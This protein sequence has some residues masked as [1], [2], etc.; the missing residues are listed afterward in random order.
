M[1]GTPRIVVIGGVAAGMS[2]AS[3]AR[4][5]R[6]QAEVIVL[7]RGP[8][9]SYGACGMP[10]N[11]GD[12]RRPI[13]DLV[14]L[15]AERF[16]AE[17]GIDV[18]TGQEALALDTVA[19]T[20]RVLDVAAGRQY[21]L[22]YDALV[23]ATGASAVAPSIPGLGLPGVFRLR[24][25]TDGAA[26]K[27]HL[28]AARPTRAV[29]VGA[30]YIGMEMAEVLTRR[31]LSVT[32]LE[33]LDQVVPGF[34]PAIARLVAQELA[35]HGVR[36]ETGITV[37]AIERLPEAAGA[38]SGDPLVVRT[39]RGAFLAGLVIVSVGVRPNVALAR[40]AGIALGD[41]GAIRVDAGMR[42]SVPDVF[43][44]GDCAEA[45]HRV[46][47]RPAWVPL[48]TTANKQGKVAGANAAGADESFAGIVGTAAF[49]VFDL[50][51]ARTGLGEAEAGRLGLG[52]VAAT[53][54]HRSRGHA[55][56][57]GSSITTV[58]LA[59]RG[60]GR[61][62]GGQ[63]AGGEGVAKRIDVLAAVLH[64]RG[65][66]ED[67]EQLDLSYAPP[68][69]PV[70]DPLLV[71]ATVARKELASAERGDGARRELAVGPALSAR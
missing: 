39:D 7:E 19:R 28:Q 22:P 17:R 6:P 25:L 11:I 41:T 21:V 47:G 37:Q 32:V 12:D 57:G 61:L 5:R 66:V 64:A 33:K 2:A 42:T 23:L 36:A 24:E 51:V 31:G 13:E 46:S 44:A 35:G 68:F 9:V 18:R 29:I 4:R 10:Y 52:S 20:V 40:A 45:E 27:D 1:A 53:S 48:G 34:D 14:V 55:Y 63:M 60:S 65:T 8:H 3:Q 58:L 38:E 70:Y 16:R 59:E 67:L 71:A 50:E 56:P 26:I 49:R 15:T 69:A 62:L 43:A 54:V 30:G